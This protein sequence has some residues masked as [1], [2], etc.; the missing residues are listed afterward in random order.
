MA[1]LYHLLDTD[2]LE[3][4]TIMKERSMYLFIHTRKSNLDGMF[5]KII[6]YP[7]AINDDI[8]N[9]QNR[10]LIKSV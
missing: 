2:K 7:V 3:K 6:K 8:P 1:S 9:E 5:E 10:R 4:Q